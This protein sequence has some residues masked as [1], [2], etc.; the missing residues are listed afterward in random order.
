MA[1]PI[2]H[3]RYYLRG[4]IFEVEVETGWRAVLNLAKLLKI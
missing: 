4:R 3:Y 2:T 1:Q